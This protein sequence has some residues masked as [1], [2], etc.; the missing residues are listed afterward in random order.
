MDVTHFP[1]PFISWWIFRLF[2]LL[3]VRITT[4]MNIH[5]QILDVYFYLSKNTPSSGI[6]RSR[7]DHFTFKQQ[8][9]CFLSSFIILHLMQ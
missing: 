6:A 2:S 8:L 9:D 5:I 7:G 3:A 4:T 1:Y